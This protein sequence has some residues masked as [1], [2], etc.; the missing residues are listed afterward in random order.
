MREHVQQLL[1]AAVR[2]RAVRA[3]AVAAVLLTAAVPAAAASVSSGAHPAAKPAPK[4]IRPDA[5]LT[6]GGASRPGTATPDVSLKGYRKTFYSKGG[7][8]IVDLTAWAPHVDWQRIGDEAAVASVYVDGRYATDLLVP[9]STP[10]KRELQLGDLAAGRHTLTA[11]F[12]GDR[13]APRARQL[14]IAKLYVRTVSAGDPN[15]VALA[16]SPIL[17]GR[18]LA[19]YGGPFQNAWTDAPLVAWH[20]A[21]PQADGT[22]MLEYQIVWSNED[23]GTDT[24]PPSEQARWGRMTDIEWIYRVTVDAQGKTVPGS[25][26]FQA[27]SHVTSTFTGTHEGD[28]AVLQTCTDN[29]NVCDQ[30]SDAKMRFFLS[31]EPTMNATTQAR[32]QIM[33]MNPWTYA[34]MGK[35]MVR[36]HHTEAKADPAT[37]ELSDARNYLYVVIN[38]TTNMAND[39]SP[40]VGVAIG[41]RLKGDPTLYRSDHTIPAWSLQRDGEDATDVELPAGMT[42][43]D[44][45]QIELIRFATS[46]RADPG[47][48]VTVTSMNRAYLLDRNYNPVRPYLTWQ[49]TI[50][51]TKA[52]PTATIWQRS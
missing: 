13:S 26:T 36:E 12:A 7:Q 31:T 40:W 50:T 8:G 43:S 52:Q 48:V 46:E 9:G 38:K 29:N 39:V 34:V 23:G 27:P 21:A 47:S 30:L 2:S 22:T 5:V 44:I 33:E 25:E 1:T 3:G 19:S 32:E 42:T 10:L 20:Y 14:D 49:G 37:A 11:Y 16:H 51:L 28:H 41:V 35:E 18:S 6:R 4:Q 15:Y 17:Y 24:E 45:K